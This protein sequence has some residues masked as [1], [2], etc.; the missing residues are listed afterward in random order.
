MKKIYIYLICF[1][2]IFFIFNISFAKDVRKEIIVMTHDS[3]SVSKS[4]IENFEKKNN[5]KVKF[6]KSGDAGLALTQAIL[7]KNNPMADIFFGVDNTFFTRAIHADIFERYDSPFLS[8]IDD[9]LKLDKKNRLI[10]IDFGDVCL[11]YDKKWFKEKNIKPPSSL[12]D[13]TK[14]QYHG[15]T[16]VQNPAT[17]SPGLAFLLAT[18]GYFGENDYLTFWAKLKQ[19][20]VLI[21]DGWEKAY[22]GHFSFHS[23]ENRPIV[24]SYATSPAAEIYFSE[25]PLKKAPTAAITGDVTCF[26]QIEFAGILKGTKKRGLSEKFIDYMISKEFQEDIPLQMFVFPANKTVNLPDIFKKYAKLAKK[27]AFVSYEAVSKN[28]SK[29]IEE[30][31]RLMLR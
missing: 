31:T 30:W 16:I 27:P 8:E 28:R 13:L 2:S 23:K 22:W 7:S 18:I 15:L 24:V 29:W 19:N 12:N 25:T 9:N 4:V 26:R 10:P 17:S 3:F 20:N 5:A 14:P 1:I 21:T 11:N 6:L